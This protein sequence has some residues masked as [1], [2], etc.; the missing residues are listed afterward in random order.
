MFRRTTPTIIVVIPKNIDAGN[1]RTL[2]LTCTQ[3]GIE[4][5]HFTDLTHESGTQVY[6]KTLTQEQTA[7]LT[8]DVDLVMQVRLKTY[9]DKAYASKVMR[10]KVC[11]VLKDGDM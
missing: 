11:D 2:W 6:K 4:V 1:I 3:K 7:T 8:P 9:D 10:V 5:F